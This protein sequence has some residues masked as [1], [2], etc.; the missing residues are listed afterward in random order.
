M[1]ASKD[2]TNRDQP[3][4]GKGVLVCLVGIDGSGKSTLAKSLVSAAKDSNLRCRYVYAGFTSSFTIFRPVVALA[5]ATLFRGNNH[6]E[7]SATKGTVLR[8]SR[9]SAIYQYLALTD[10]I[11]QTWFRVGLPL[12]R[13]GHV[14]CDRYIYDLV[15]SI[16]VLL[17]Y[18]LDRTLALLRRC[19][20]FLPKPQLVFLLDLPEALAY[21]R[22]DDIVS[23]TFLAAR[24]EIYLEMA[25]L[26]QFTILDASASQESLQQLAAARVLGVFGGES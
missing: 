22:K 8:H 9:L 14:V 26:H 23:L 24:R 15:A 2:D 18:P 1:T 13:G 10:Y 16:G 4:D 19:L 6:M 3:L 5:K 21:E 20:G 12:A 7:T 11:V 17:D 25:R